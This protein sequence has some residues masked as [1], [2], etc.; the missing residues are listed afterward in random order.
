MLIYPP[1]FSLVLQSRGLGSSWLGFELVCLLDLLV[2]CDPWPQWQF[3][4]V[5]KYCL[6]L[7]SE[8]Q[9]LRCWMASV[10]RRQLRKTELRQEENWKVH[11][12]FSVGR[13]PR[14]GEAPV[15]ETFP[16]VLTFSA[17]GLE[18]AVELCFPSARRS[19]LHFGDLQ[20]WLVWHLDVILSINVMASLNILNIVH[21]PKFCHHWA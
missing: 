2:G 20:G 1:S 15:V 9:T 18:C 5:K 16:R 21:T 17:C 10:L 12:P 4:P 3:C 6:G 19:V 11:W 8:V 7:N 14:R 13:R